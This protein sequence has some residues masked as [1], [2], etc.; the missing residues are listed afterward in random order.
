MRQTSTAR[1]PENRFKVLERDPHKSVEFEL[2]AGYTLEQRENVLPGGKA[3]WAATLTSHTYEMSVALR[4]KER[5]SIEAEGDHGVINAQGARVSRPRTGEVLRYK[6]V[7][8]AYEHI[9]KERVRRQLAG[10]EGEVVGHLTEGLTQREIFN[11]IDA[12]ALDAH[13]APHQQAK[14]RLLRDICLAIWPADKRQWDKD[15]VEYFFLKRSG[16]FPNGKKATEAELR[17]KGVERVGVQFPTHIKRAPLPPCSP[18]TCQSNLKDL[19]TYIGYLV[20][21]VDKK[22]KQKYLPH[23]PLEGLKFG[24]IRKGGKPV[25]TVERYHWLRIAADKAMHRHNEEIAASRNGGREFFVPMLSALLAVAYHTGQRID[26][27][28][29][30]LVDD[31]RKTQGSM[32]K[33]LRE[34]IKNTSGSDVPQEEWCSSW[35]SGLL[36]FRKEWSKTEYD[37]PVPINPQLADI[38]DWYLAER[39]KAGVNSPWLFW[40]PADPSRPLRYDD[41]HLLL[42][43]AE[44][45]A[46]ELAAAVG[47]DAD[48]LI[49]DLGD[50]AWHGFRAL[51]EN[52]RDD[53]GWWMN[54]NSAW[55]GGWTTKIGGPQN[56]SYR[57][58]K[59]H[60]VFAVVCGKSV[61][62][63]VEDAEETERARRAI[64][65][66]V[67][68]YDA[69]VS[70]TELR[71]RGLA[72]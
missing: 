39:K 27:I 34:A 69:P 20:G 2:P 47:E 29:H 26:A 30:L 4:E 62:E 41:A 11:L 16:H 36:Y 61:M 32:R 17:K 42:R 57:R 14:N 65:G 13:T 1:R 71:G 9:E 45:E 63:V 56:T 64:Q 55:A 6:A 53:L 52:L 31:Y 23:H 51:W 60:Y 58:L 54:K 25:P 40:S 5:G 70:T 50:Q 35:S 19:K 24:T 49:P 3:G 12:K 10:D 43:R 44:N 68:R 8:W 7:E 46:R 48:L 59:P 37:R 67:V 28:L 66:D 33:A 72:A 22:S 15:D 38:L 18:Q 21:V